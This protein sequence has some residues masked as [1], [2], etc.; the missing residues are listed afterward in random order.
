M[1]FDLSSFN[2]SNTDLIVNPYPVYEEIRER[3]PIHHSGMYGGSWVL[4]SYEDAAALLRDRRLTNNRATLPVLALPE[5]QR[6]EFDDF[7]AFLRTWTAFFEGDDHILR[8][9][10]MDEVFRL[11]TP[12]RVTAV[13]QGV[14]D[15]LIDSWAGRDEVDLVADLARPL[16]AMI[17]TS[18]MGAPESDHERLDGWADDI[19]YLFGASALTVED[20]RRGWA[21]ARALMAYLRELAAEMDRSPHHSLLGGLM[22]QQLP[23]FGFTEAEA[24]AQ[25]V[26]LMFAG[27]EPSRHLIG[28]AMLALQ[29]FP[30]QRRLLDDNPRLWPAAVEEFLRFDPPVQYI[31]R[32]AAESF[33]YRGRDF[34]KGQAVLPFVVSANRDPRQFPNPDTLDVARR[35][36]HLSMGE[37]VHRC[38]GAGLVRIQTAVALRTLLTRVP[39]LEVCANPPPVWHSYVGF[40][41]LKS[42]TVSI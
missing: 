25:C 12:P 6:A 13:V 18:L 32:V 30:D 11:L 27:L 4:F 24:C 1:N 5:H 23:G 39:H 35:A 38:V 41:G 42:L 19:A 22:S 17:L 3:D 15:R 14:V 28:N 21:S 26:L 16:P 2:F 29:R 34:E 40:H 20:L 33:T 9:R 8:R 37:G 7:V 10:R 36:K 31:G